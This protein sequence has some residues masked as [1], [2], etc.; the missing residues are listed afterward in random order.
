MNKKIQML[1]SNPPIGLLESMAT[2]KDHGFGLPGIGE[3]EKQHKERQES[4]L[5][6]MKK[7]YDEV[8]GQGYYNYPEI[9]S[10]FL[11]KE[12]DFKNLSRF[13]ETSSD[14]EGYDVRAEDMERLAEIGV[15]RYHGK[16]E[17]SITSFGQSVLER[18]NID[19]L[20]KTLE[21]EK[22]SWK[23]A[24]ERIMSGKNK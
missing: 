2:C 8:A 20:S 21:T 14:G 9:E 23:A 16:K 3:D 11:I 12:N 19:S 10:L 5:Y 24:E 15:V 13:E 18:K 17:Y 1:P 7:L 22:D 6:L 4:I